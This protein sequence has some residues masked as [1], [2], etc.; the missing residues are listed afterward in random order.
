MVTVWDQVSSFAESVDTF[1]KQM[2]KA[3]AMA[4]NFI[5]DVPVLVLAMPR[6]PAR[7]GMREPNALMVL[8]GNNRIL[9]IAIRASR[10]LPLPPVVAVFVR[11]A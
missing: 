1:G 9:A 5:V 3:Q 4:E 11:P 10:N 7:H 6:D 2:P 8:E